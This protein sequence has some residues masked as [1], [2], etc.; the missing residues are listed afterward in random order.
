MTNA[1]LLRKARVE[2]AADTARLAGELGYATPVEAMHERLAVL[3][4][5][6]DHCIAVAERDGHMLGWIAVEHRR[7]LESGERVEI[8]GLVVDAQ[9]RGSGVGRLLVQ[10]AEQWAQQL[11]FGTLCVRSNVLRDASHPF[12]ERMGYVRRK[13]QHYYVKTLFQAGTP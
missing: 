13:T 7:T 11:G 8:V 1:P 6:P 10:A 12:Y 3:A 9:R 2:D 4:A 5:H